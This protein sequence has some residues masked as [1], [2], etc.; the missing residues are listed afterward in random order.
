MQKTSKRYI[1]NWMISYWWFLMMFR[2]LKVPYNHVPM[3]I[4]Q[5]EGNIKTYNKLFSFLIFL[6][7]PWITQ[8]KKLSWIFNVFYIVLWWKILWNKTSFYWSRG[9]LY[10][11]FVFMIFYSNVFTWDRNFLSETWK[12]KKFEKLKNFSIEVNQIRTLNSMSMI[13]KGE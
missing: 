10:R 11:N 6:F 5:I 13:K 7:L 8:T 9:Y 4:L 3:L 2:T 12:K 1:Q